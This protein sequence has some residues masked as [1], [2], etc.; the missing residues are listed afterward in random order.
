MMAG[1]RSSSLGCIF[2]VFRERLAYLFL[3]A[4]L[5]IMRRMTC[6]FSCAACGRRFL[7]ESRSPLEDLVRACPRSPAGSS[8][9]TRVHSR[10]RA[11]PVCTS[12]VTGWSFPLPVG[13]RC[14]RRGQRTWIL[15]AD[16]VTFDLVGMLWVWRSLGNPGLVGPEFLRGPART[17]RTGNH[18]YYYGISL[19]T[20][21]WGG[22][23]WPAP[24]R[25]GCG[26][27]AL[28]GGVHE[29]P[30]TR[31][32]LTPADL[33]PITGGWG[34]QVQHLNLTADVGDK[35]L[36][37]KANPGG[38]APKISPPVTLRCQPLTLD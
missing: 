20:M 23:H 30:L 9:M 18:A 26:T 24:F 33:A 37:P 31:G 38:V 28:S 25:R 29:C 14:T 22:S 7:L 35:S 3:C 6:C 36:S 5:V 34:G 21:F 27:Q 13:S 15:V 2:T 16:R 17:F 10:L 11:S 1:F 19:F 8:Y 4:T 32:A 12:C